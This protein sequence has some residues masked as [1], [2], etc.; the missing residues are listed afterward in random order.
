MDKKTLGRAVK[1]EIRNS[2]RHNA[3]HPVEI[4][5]NS[6]PVK[7]KCIHQ[8]SR[9]KIAYTKPFPALPA[10]IANGLAKGVGC[11]MLSILAFPLPLI[12]GLGN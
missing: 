8:F 11:E 1:K 6:S 5:V 2:Y 7:R 10:S 9:A 12:N 4:R 3:Y